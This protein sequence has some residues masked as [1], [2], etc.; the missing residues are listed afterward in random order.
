METSG[1]HLDVRTLRRLIIAGVVV[2]LGLALGVKVATDPELVIGAIG[3]FALLFL[4]VTKPAYFCL[5]TLFFLFSAFDLIDVATFGR[6]PGLFKAKDVFIFML[7]GFT[8]ANIAM[9]VFP[10]GILKRS[11]L[12]APLMLFLGFVVLQ[13]LR[14]KFVLGESTVLLFRQGRHFLNYA[15]AFVL[16]LY[17]RTDRDWKRLEQFCVFCVFLACAVNIIQTLGLP[18]PKYMR[19]VM[20]DPRNVGAVKSLNP[21]FLLTYWMFYRQFWQFVYKPD[22]S[23]AF[24]LIGFGV[25]VIFYFFRTFLFTSMVSM[26]FVSVFFIPPRVRV[27]ALGTL[28]LGGLASIVLSLFIVAAVKSYSLGY[29]TSVMTEYLAGTVMN[30]IEVGGSYATRVEVDRLRYPLIIQHPFMGVGFLSVFGDIAYEIWQTR[31]ELA[32]DTTDTGW[33][34]LLLRLGGVGYAILMFV[35]VS[36]TWLCWRLTKRRD[37]SLH[38]RGLLCANATLFP[39]ALLSMIASNPLGVESGIALLSIAL[40]WTIRLEQKAREGTTSIARSPSS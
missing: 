18:V 5:L 21:A 15:M 10:R 17:F 4:L 25:P 37:W 9:D 6:I 23:N 35:F 13:M 19:S 12:F 38:E 28:A 29:L 22:R 26:I 31:G 24:R 39:M 8:L 16:L 2:S 32:L 20:V 40:A 3:L 36:A 11:R 33:V 34:D 14:T 30:V 7:F 27:R 1:A